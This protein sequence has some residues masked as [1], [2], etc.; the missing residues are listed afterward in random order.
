MMRDGFDTAIIDMQ[1]GLHTT[2]SAILAIGAAAVAGKAVFVRPPVGDFPAASRMLDAGAVGIVAP[3]I[4]TIEDARKLAAYTKY[5]PLGER[6]WG[7]YRATGL[8][9]LDGVAYLKAAN[10]ITLTI[11]MIETREALGILDDIL[12][13]PGIDGVFVGPS[14]LSIALTRGETVDQFHPEVD[15]ALTY[16]ELRAML[17]LRLALL[18]L[19]LLCVLRF[20]TVALARSLLLL[21]ALALGA[22]LLSG[23]EDVR[24]IDGVDVPCIGI[25]R[26]DERPDYVYRL[27]TRNIVVGVIFAGFVAPP[28]VVL[29]DELYCPVARKAEV[30]R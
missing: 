26:V 22:S 15:A 10:D 27:S 18:L 6:S 8:T 20:V 17:A 4:N 30:A 14:D 3:M 2:Q 28:I 21:A 25:E 9:G 24:E 23:C 29:L 7:P 11:A 19:A 5:P 13:V 1:H 12:A 16:V